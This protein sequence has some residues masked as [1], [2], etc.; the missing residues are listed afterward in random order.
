MALTWK[1]HFPV[2]VM[3]GEWAWDI[4]LL[5]TCPACTKL[6]VSPTLDFLVE[7]IA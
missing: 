7:S 6:W 3:L 2:A 5:L 1:A 4:F